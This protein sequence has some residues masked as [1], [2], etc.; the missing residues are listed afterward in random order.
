MKRLSMVCSLVFLML[1]LGISSCATTKL[2]ISERYV[3]SN[4]VTALFFYRD[5]RLEVSELYDPKFVYPAGNWSREHDIV[6]IQ[7]LAQT[8]RFRVAKH[9]NG[10]SLTLLNAEECRDA[11]TAWRLS[12]L[13]LSD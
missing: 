11:V 1:T 12:E 9:R 3:A 8:L 4:G 7:S 6:R 10:T 13:Y 5:G 2:T